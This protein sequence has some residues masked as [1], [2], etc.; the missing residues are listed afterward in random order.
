MI[1]QENEQLHKDMMELKSQNNRLLNENSKLKN[2]VT[3]L[4][5]TLQKLVMQTDSNPKEIP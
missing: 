2:Q 3:E 5:S 4:T 1:M